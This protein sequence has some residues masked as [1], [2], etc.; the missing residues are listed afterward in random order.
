MS[1][2]PRIIAIESI[3]ATRL[4]EMQ[5]VDLE[6][7]NGQ[8]ARF[9]RLMGQGPGSVVVVPMP[10]AHHVRLIKEYAVGFERYELGFVKGKIDDGETPQHAASRELRE[11]IGCRAGTLQHL[12]TVTVTPGYSNFQSWIFLASEL[13]HD[14][15]EGDEPEELETQDWP[16]N[17]FD[18]L[19]TRQDFTDA[20][21]VLATY[22]VESQLK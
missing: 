17:Q 4:F 22:L 9:H 16:I 15:L 2:L 8:T 10:D 5:R 21:C 14:P 6:F 12:T 20:R 19:R 7:A 3:A 18:A 11:E 13:S 1:R